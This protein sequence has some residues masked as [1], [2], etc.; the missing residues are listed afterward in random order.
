VCLALLGLLYADRHAWLA[1]LAAGLAFSAKTSAGVWI[2][3]GWLAAAWASDPARRTIRAT[4]G[5]LAAFTVA[6][7]FATLL[8]Y[9]ALWRQP[10]DAMAEMW[11][12]RQDLLAAQTAAIGSVMPWAV[13]TGPGDRAAVSLV[14]LYFAPLQFAEASN[15]LAE[16]AA[17]EAAYLAQPSHALFRGVAGGAVLLGLTVLGVAL[18]VGRVRSS[19]PE[20]RRATGVALLATAV[21]AGALVAAV[22]LAFQRYV[23][24]LVPLVCLWSGYALAWLVQQLARNLRR[25]EAASG[26]K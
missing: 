25:K 15:Y 16:T 4:L 19:E 3:F 17:S 1:G 18:G 23:I 26:I 21:Q 13:L 8:M 14:N 7:G 22:P 10:F 24:P 11:R 9:P 6:A 2:P 20:N 12:A 5:R